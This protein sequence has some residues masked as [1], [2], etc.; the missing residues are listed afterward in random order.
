MKKAF[1][2]ILI[3]AALLIAWA[4]GRN[5][6]IQHAITSSEIWLAEYEEPEDGNGDWVINID[7]DGQTYQHVIWVY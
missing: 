6:G 2:F 5:S 1:T 4:D 3:V 7:L